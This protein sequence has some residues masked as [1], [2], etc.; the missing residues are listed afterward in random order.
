MTA[1]RIPSRLMPRGLLAAASLALSAC[2]A[3]PPP[4]P[5]GVEA[6]PPLPPRS[7]HA[8][9]FYVGAHPDDIELFMGRNAWLDVAAPDRRVVFIVL[10]AGDAGLGTDYF[11][12]RENGHERALRFWASLDAWPLAPT[13]VSTVSVAGHALERRAIGRNVSSYNLRL[14]DGDMEGE[15]YAVTG[16]ESLRRLQAGAVAQLHSVDGR[17]AMSYADLKAV[18]GGLVALEAHGSKEVWVSIQDED[19]Q[20]NLE[21]HAD[22]TATALAVVDT[23]R[24]A[25]F[26]CVGLARYLDYVVADKPQNLSAA[27]TLLHAGTWGALNS[28]RVDGAQVTT[29]DSQHVAWIGRE[30]FRIEAPRASC[31]F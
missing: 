31:E 14:P 20:R 28:G 5:A 12:A 4:A 13:S 11:M 15:G 29:W 7:P 3:L 25:R 30:Y 19:R 9:V 23:L 21:D 26:S 27:E 10:T 17:Q 2:A 18:L 24:E 16:R 6:A 22:H 8:T 1:R